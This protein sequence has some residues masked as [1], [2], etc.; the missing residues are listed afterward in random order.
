L[1]PTQRSLAIEFGTR[2]GTW[3][4]NGD[5]IAVL[6]N[7]DVTDHK[8]QATTGA[9][10]FGAGI[11]WNDG[12]AYWAWVDFDGVT[13]TLSV[14]IAEGASQPGK[15]G[16]A[17]LNYDITTLAGVDDLTD[18]LGTQACAGFSAAS[19]GLTNTHQ[20]LEWEMMTLL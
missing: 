7:G 2:R 9:P 14:Y 16:T 15:P 13:E 11:D 4:I 5:H 8:V 20:I 18:M 19:G 10:G 3:D 12:D 1:T 17:V 6:V